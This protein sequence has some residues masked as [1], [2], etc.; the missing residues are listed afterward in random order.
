VSASIELVAV[1]AFMRLADYLDGEA[2]SAKIAALCERIGSARRDAAGDFVD[3]ALVV[4]PE[5]I[6]TFLV[7]DPR[8][9]AAAHVRRRRRPA[10]DHERV[11][12]RRRTDLL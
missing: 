9:H 11:R 3:P 5:H 4:F 8:R 2:F 7:A 10:T 12:P 6:G 1:Q